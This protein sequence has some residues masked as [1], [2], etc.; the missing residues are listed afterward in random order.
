MSRISPAHETDNDKTYSKE[1][2]ELW[3]DNFLKAG[4]ANGY[5]WKTIQKQLNENE[6]HRERVLGSL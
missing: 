6:A 5:Y 4:K 3:L 1:V 2:L